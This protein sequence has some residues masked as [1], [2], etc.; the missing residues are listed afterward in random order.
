VWES[1]PAAGG[2][3]KFGFLVGLCAI[4][5]DASIAHGL[6]WENDPYWTYW[7]TKTFLITTVFTAGTTILGRG[8]VP[9]LV[10]TFVHTVILEVYYQ[11]LSPIGLPQEPQWLPFRDLWLHGFLV[12]YLVILAG[13]F[14]ALWI[15]RRGVARA[16]PADAAPFAV[17]ATALAAAL[18]AVVF[19]GVVTQALLVRVFPG[20]TFF[21]QHLLIAFVFAFAWITYVGLD[22]TGLLVGALLLGL[23]WTAY[24][25]YLGPIG[26]PWAPPTYLGYEDLWLR[27][28]PGGVISAAL[29]FLAVTTV[30]R[31]ALRTVASRLPV[32]EA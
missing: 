23:I 14:L 26:S 16:E 9:G 2:A 17:A 7:V 10:L 18:L 13:Y 29:A 11:W 25:M 30:L 32:G 1:E 6:W 8:L 21:V 28:L 20:L 3:A 5:L 31:D 22:R 24:S 15:W 27:S 4:F 19:D 12:H